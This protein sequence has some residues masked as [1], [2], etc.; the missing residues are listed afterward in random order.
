MSILR[1]S[2]RVT[3]V[4]ILIIFSIVDP[5]VAG[6]FLG[7]R[8][9]RRCCCQP[10]FVNGAD[11]QSRQPDAFFN[12]GE[13]SL[14]P[15]HTNNPSHTTQPQES[16]KYQ[17]GMLAPSPV[18]IP[19]IP[20]TTAI[21]E[22]AAPL[23]VKAP[24]V[25]PDISDHQPVPFR[26]T[27][28]EGD[29]A[30]SLTE[31]HAS[32]S[33]SVA[34]VLET[35]IEQERQEAKEPG[36]STTRHDSS[37]SIERQSPT[38]LYPKQSEIMEAM[39]A[40]RPEKSYSPHSSKPQVVFP[41]FKVAKPEDWSGGSLPVQPRPAIQPQPADDFLAPA[42]PT[43]EALPKPSERL[44]VEPTNY[45]VPRP[46]SRVWFRQWSDDTGLFSAYARLIEVRDGHVRLLKESGRTTTVRLDRLSRVDQDYLAAEVAREKSPTGT[47]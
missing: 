27:K 16:P 11:P 5:A 31:D 37:N 20:E 45:P 1:N 47:K 23:V 42:A 36:A 8:Q 24:D 12:E 10:L 39:S 2:I 6:R 32:E 35:L 46:P 14:N 3:L 41:R 40:P 21:G 25:A 38:R 29:L 33:S 17:D 30:K 19:R 15:N 7:C 26:E 18:T 22:I 9:R 34:P 44:T 43:P 4:A 28:P 13:L